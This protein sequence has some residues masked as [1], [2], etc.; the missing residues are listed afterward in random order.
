MSSWPKSGVV[1]L[2]T[3]SIGIVLN[4]V[5]SIGV[6]ATLRESKWKKSLITTASLSVVSI[7]VSFVQVVDWAPIV[8]NADRKWPFSNWLCGPFN[9]VETALQYIFSISIM[10]VAKDRYDSIHAH[11]AN[12]QKSRFFLILSLWVIAAI[13]AAPELFL[14]NGNNQHCVNQYANESVSQGYD[15]FKVSVTL[16]LPLIIDLIYYIN[17]TIFFCR[18]K[19]PAQQ[20][21]QLSIANEQRRLVKLTVLSTILFLTASTIDAFKILSW[22]LEIHVSDAVIL[23]Q[24]FAVNVACC[25]S[26]VPRLD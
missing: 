16:P 6:L 18:F 25:L 13:F 23:V 5:S 4:F 20:D 7:G 8:A 14:Y 12:K 17:V 21:L 24:S 15:L 26:G 19:I 3:S 9:A 2:L 22:A 11:A 1:L 10:L